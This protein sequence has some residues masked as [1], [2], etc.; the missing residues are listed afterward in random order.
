MEKLTSILVI[1]DTR[2]EMNRTLAKALFLARRFGASLELFL[3]DSER[4]YVLKHSY[5]AEEAAR[6]RQSY[7]AIDPA[8]QAVANPSQYP[9]DIEKARQV[10]LADELAYL[11]ALRESLHA[12]DVNI[13]LD[14][15]CHSPLYESIVRKV[16]QSAP[17][18]VIKSTSGRHPMRRFFLDDN[19]WQLA[20]ACPAALMLTRQRKWANPPRFAAAVDVSEHETCDTAHMILRTS[21]YLALGCQGELDVMYSETQEDVSNEREAST[22][23]QQLAYEHNVNADHTHVL[24]GQADETL[25]VFATAEH[26]DVLVLGALTHRRGFAA[27]I[28][29]LTSK[30]VDALDCDF[31]LVK[32]GNDQRMRQDAA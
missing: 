20:R 5:I 10:C 24:H 13:T 15:A 8:M 25:P 16:K 3:C 32:R 18:L 9:N 26:Y 22:K 6:A 1:V 11:S 30:L 4:A 21:E 27:L 31:V 19:D 29:T 23:L 17:D 14:V 2:N 12:S 28:G 7:V